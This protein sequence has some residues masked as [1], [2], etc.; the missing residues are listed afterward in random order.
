MTSVDRESSDAA[1]TVVDSVD[2]T[3]TSDA[4]APRALGIGA[5][6]ALVIGSIVGSG[7]F[8]LPAALAP[9]GTAT[10]YGWTITLAGAML[11]AATFARLSRRWPRSGGP[12]AY[13]REAFGDVPAF[14][15][16]WSYWISICAGNAA[17]AV[18][19]AGSVGALWPEA[20]AT[21]MRSATTALAALLVT[22]AIN[23]RGARS[24]G[25]TQV[26][27]TI[28]KLVPL[29][30]FGAVAIWFVDTSRYAPL[31]SEADALASSIHA[32]VALTL[33]A[34]LGVEAATIPA[35]AVRD[36][37]RT[38]PRATVFGTLLAGIA[39]VAACTA[40]IGLVPAAQL[41]ESSAP[42]VD[43]ARAL[44]GAP[45]AIAMALVA[46]VSCF[47]SLNG[48]VLASGHLPMAAARD[49]LLPRALARIDSRGTPAFAIALSASLSGALIVSNY[50]RS[51][52]QLFTL[53]ILLATA[54]TLLPYVASTAAW[55]HRGER[56]GRLVAFAALVYSLYALAG[57]GREAMLW[58]AALLAM[59]L[60]VYFVVRA[61]NQ[62]P[63]TSS[64]PPDSRP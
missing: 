45:A 5:A 52:V 11:L 27:T 1:G 7:V 35:D 64:L 30:A 37:A 39:T 4:S 26:L 40:A 56:R 9:F 22:T 48:W 28:L 44:W 25:W 15:V 21:P 6:T 38:I 16:V 50:T 8:L 57:I 63:V 19:F 41:A 43:A 47:G 61:G 20:T 60:P 14:V 23:L 33:W 46:A 29:L 3:G 31:P 17:I 13:T 32:T 51:L 58:G 36:P 12:Y 2:A 34:L 62:A 55:L 54:A 18:A 53:T 49:G 10:L 59:A 42:M 24:A